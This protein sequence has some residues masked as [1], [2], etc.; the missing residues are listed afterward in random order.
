MELYRIKEIINYGGFFAGE[1]VSIVAVPYGQATPELDFTIDEG[2]FHN[3]TDRH[4][5]VAG[6]VLALSVKD[7]NKVTEA[8]ILAAE[9]RTALREAVDTSTPAE[10]AYR[11][12][13]FKCPVCELWVRGEPEKVTADRY[14]CRVCGETFEA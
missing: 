3:L 13:A 8:Y 14:T 5:I 10:K 2:V 4:K 11:V 9:S 7:D 12:F 1:T 6:M